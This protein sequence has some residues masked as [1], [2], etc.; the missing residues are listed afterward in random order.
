MFKRD[1]GTTSAIQTAHERR[2]GKSAGTIL[3]QG[4]FT[5]LNL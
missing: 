4:S 1:W 5:V 3:S 2:S